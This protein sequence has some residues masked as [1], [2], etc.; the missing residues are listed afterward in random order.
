VADADFMG[1]FGVLERSAPGHGM[2]SLHQF[3]LWLAF[4]SE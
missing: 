1:F 2:T 3:F 4:L